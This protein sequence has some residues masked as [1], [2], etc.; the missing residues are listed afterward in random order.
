MWL[1][2]LRR[3]PIG[4]VQTGQTYTALPSSPSDPSIECPSD[5]PGDADLSAAPSSSALTAS[6]AWPPGCSRAEGLTLAGSSLGLHSTISLS[7]VI[8]ESAI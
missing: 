6:A 3:L 1:C 5:A 4:T 8:L 7:F 2:K